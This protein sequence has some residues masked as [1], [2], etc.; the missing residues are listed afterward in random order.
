MAQWDHSSSLKS[1][2]SSSS[3]AALSPAFLEY[4]RKMGRTTASN[5]SMAL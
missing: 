5:L 4:L 3:A 2:S 1:K